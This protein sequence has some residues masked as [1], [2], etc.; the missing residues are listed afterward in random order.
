MYR[1][2]KSYGII[3]I[4]R[5]QREGRSVYQTLMVRK[6]NTYSFVIFVSGGYSTNDYAK[7]SALVATMTAEERG[8]L[9]SRN[10]EHIWRRVWMDTAHRKYLTAL[11]KYEDLMTQSRRFIDM[12]MHIQEF[13]HLRWEIPKGKKNTNDETELQAATREFIEET[14]I[15]K[16]QFTLLADI[17]RDD[18]YVD[19]STRY[20]TR[21]FCAIGDFVPNR[22]HRHLNETS[23]VRWMDM[24]ELRV[25]DR[26]GYSHM[27]SVVRPVIRRLKKE[28]PSA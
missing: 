17:I 25:S 8:L 10:F 18:S 24:E 28:F 1:E 21:Y 2:R 13:G 16:S 9:L 19:D 12:L 23:E 22:M 5:I 3:C 4:R 26:L 20:T 11:R 14:G 27:A 6:H 15:K 7:I